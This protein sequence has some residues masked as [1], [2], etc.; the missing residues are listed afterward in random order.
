[1]ADRQKAMNVSARDM[2]RFDSKWTPEPFSG[3]WLWTGHLNARG[4]GGIW[5]DG[6]NRLAHRVAWLIYR[7]ELP[8]DKQMCHH[9]DTPSCVNPSHLFPGSASDNLR[10][11]MAKG[12]RR[13]STRLVCERGHVVAGANLYIKPNGF[14]DCV[15]CRREAGIRFKRRKNGP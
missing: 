15:A 4:Y 12:R 1:M 13:V 7:G 2:A 6:L 3:C 5:I 8:A 14:S 9:C 11:S 10:D